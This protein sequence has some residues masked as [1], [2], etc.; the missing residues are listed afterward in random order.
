MGVVV[1]VLEKIAILYSGPVGEVPG[2]S[3]TED[4]STEVETD[5]TASKK[6]AVVTRHLI[7][8]VGDKGRPAC[9][10]VPVLE[11]SCELLQQLLDNGL[12][13][14]RCVSF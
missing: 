11:R 9:S 6:H 10:V 3:G 1:D 12:A 2:R 8:L 5:K 4:V 13:V 14:F 7:Q